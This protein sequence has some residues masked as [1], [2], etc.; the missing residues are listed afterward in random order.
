MAVSVVRLDGMLRWTRG[1]FFLFEAVAVAVAVAVVATDAASC[2][3]C[4]CFFLLVLWGK[5]E[6]AVD[7]ATVAAMDVSNRNNCSQFAIAEEAVDLFVASVTAAAA[8][9]GKATLT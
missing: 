6:A 5:K 8:A 1:V 4:F 7:V 3:V 9:S 2:F